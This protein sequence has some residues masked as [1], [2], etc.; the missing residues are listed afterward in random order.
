MI[1]QGVDEEGG[2]F[3]RIIIRR[4]RSIKKSNKS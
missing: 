3:A 4:N 2:G 1:E